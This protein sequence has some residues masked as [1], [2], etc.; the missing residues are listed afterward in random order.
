MDKVP[1]D[2]IDDENDTNEQFPVDT[3]EVR[4][5]RFDIIGKG[6]DFVRIVVMND[7]STPQHKAYHEYHYGNTG[8]SVEDVTSFTMLSGTMAGSQEVIDGFVGSMAMHLDIP[9]AAS[10]CRGVY[11][12]SGARKRLYKATDPDDSTKMIGVLIEQDAQGKVG[13]ITWYKTRDA[14][15]LFQATPSTL[16]FELVKDG[17]GAPSLDPNHIGGFTWYY[18]TSLV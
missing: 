9:Q 12:P 16:V 3:H 5:V 2:I 7:K 13:Q 8:V 18:S 15:A 11:A 10:F 6:I 4:K 17:N 1:P 14:N